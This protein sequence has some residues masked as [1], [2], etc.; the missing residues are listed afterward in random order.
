M[1]GYKFTTENKAQEALSLVNDSI[2]FPEGGTTTSWTNYSYAG[3][4]SP[5]FYFIPSDSHTDTIL[6]GKETFEV[7]YSEY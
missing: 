3:E 5:E 2:T 6:K 7:V 1:E 4:N